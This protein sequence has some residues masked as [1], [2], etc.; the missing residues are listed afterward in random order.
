MKKVMPTVFLLLILPLLI[1]LISGCSTLRTAAYQGDTAKVKVLLDQGAD[2]NDNINGETVLSVASI[3]GHVN[4]VRLLL[5]RG[6]SVNKSIGYGL[7]PLFYALQRGHTDVAR[8]LI[9]RGGDVD[10]AMAKFKS[11]GAE[12]SQGLALLERL[13]GKQPLPAVA[14]KPVPAY[15]SKSG[16][17]ETAASDI[18]NIPDFKSEPRDHDFAVVIGIESY[19]D[20]PPSDYS[21]SDARIVKDYLKA[22]GFRERNIELI[23]NEKAT[24]SGIEK[25]VEAWLPNRVK[26]DSRV[27]LYYSGHGAPDPAKG[28]AYLVP[29]DGDPGYLPITGY[30]L[31]RLYEKL[32]DL[33]AAEVIV[34]LDSC[35]SGAGGRSILAKGARPLVM[36]IDTPLLSSKIAVLSATQ[37]SQ[38]STSSAEKGH[39]VFT[40][41]LLK[42]LQDGK[43]DIAEIYV[44]IKP[45]VEDEAKA[46][47]VQ[48][49]PSVSPDVDKLR[50]RFSFRK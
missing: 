28:E 27:F 7:T 38:I 45:L 32:G 34:V 18:R 6:A 22:L 1:S 48:Q 17:M 12:G 39:G 42:A 35:F 19:Q 10:G 24:K 16:T 9:E 50:G 11:Q 30:S 14:R 15:F 26:Q 20:L 29:Y 8:L 36:M 43:K 33:R 37:G 44:Y 25:A 46:M 5:D 4:T 31:K 49:S 13:T 21:K 2:V 47:N 23:T 41:Y 40:Y 3:Q